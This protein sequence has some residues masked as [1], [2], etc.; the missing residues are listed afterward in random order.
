MRYPN[1][2]VIWFVT[3]SEDQTILPWVFPKL[4][5]GKYGERQLSCYTSK[6]FKLHLL[7]SCQNLPPSSGFTSVAFLK[8]RSLSFVTMSFLLELPT[9]STST[10]TNS[11]TKKSFIPVTAMMITD[12][13]LQWNLYPP[14]AQQSLYRRA[15]QRG[16]FL[17]V[18]SESPDSTYRFCW[19]A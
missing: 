10:P 13:R 5:C 9:K 14:T 4:Y 19:S 17:L 15:V 11:S 7:T 6:Y 1:V 2:L 16:S 18:R 12:L 8:S 3:L